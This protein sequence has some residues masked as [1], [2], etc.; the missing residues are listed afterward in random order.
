MLILLFQKD[1]KQ[2]EAFFKKFFISLKTHMRNINKEV[3]TK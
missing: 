3:F 1:E 2:N